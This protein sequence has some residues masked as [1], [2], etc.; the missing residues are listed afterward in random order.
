MFKCKTQFTNSHT[1]DRD[2]ISNGENTIIKPN[3]SWLNRWTRGAI[4]DHDNIYVN[5]IFFVNA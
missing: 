1:I 5:Q 2:E 4:S 3:H